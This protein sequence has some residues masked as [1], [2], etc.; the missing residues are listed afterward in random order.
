MHERFI[1]PLLASLVLSF[2]MPQGTALALEKPSSRP[3]ADQGIDPQFDKLAREVV[4]NVAPQKRKIAVIEFSDMNGRVT[5][6]GK[7]IAEELTTR[8]FSTGRFEVIERQLITRVL[9]EQELGMTGLLDEKSTKK[10]GAILGVDLLVTGTTA[11]LGTTVKI[12]ARTIATD[13]GAVYSVASAVL[14]KNDQIMKLTGTGAED[15]AD[16][17]R[18]DGGSSQA[19]TQT[20]KRE[21]SRGTRTQ[22]NAKGIM[23]KGGL[24]FDGK[25]LS[26]YTK[27]SAT[28]RIYTQ[29]LGKWVTP[30]YEYD[31]ETATFTLHVIAEGSYSV[32][33]EVDANGTNPERYPGDYKGSGHFSAWFTTA[34][35]VKID[36]EKI[37]HLIEPQDNGKPQAGWGAW[38]FNKVQLGTPV[39]FSWEP[40]EKDVYYTYTVNRTV[41]SP[42]AQKEMVAGDTTTATSVTLD[43]P[44]NNDGEIYLLKIE[45]RKN[46][47]SVGSIMV[48]G[49]NGYGW[50]YRFRAVK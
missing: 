2:A 32:N 1:L 16:P 40:V 31:P 34:P 6:L 7:F 48:H 46:G 20:A 39:R 22:D 3:A 44:P 23:I 14:P 18:T 30:A 17:V 12:N 11:D 24:Y 13:T 28:L 45:A 41:C 26:N 43:L 33:A 19:A 25:P 8:L 35:V 10:V 27:A 42:F 9:K 47:R 38:C 49:G 5:N 36:M 4:A 29:D 37:I 21:P 15:R 50:D